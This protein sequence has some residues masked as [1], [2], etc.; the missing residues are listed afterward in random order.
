MTKLA[1]YAPVVHKIRGKEV[2][3]LGRVTYG[4]PGYR[5]I[6]KK[7]YEEFGQAEDA[8]ERAN[9]ELGLT[10]DEA[11]LLIENTMMGGV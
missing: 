5:A 4:V 3:V 6:L 2:F 11:W 8:A 9:R 1:G 7:R 10:E